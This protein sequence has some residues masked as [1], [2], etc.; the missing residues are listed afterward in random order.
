[1]TF[2]VAGFGLPACDDGLMIRRR[3]DGFIGRLMPVEVRLL[4]Q[5]RAARGLSARNTGACAVARVILADGTRAGTDGVYVSCDATAGRRTF[6]HVTFRKT[7]KTV[8]YYIEN[9]PTI[10]GVDAGRTRIDY[11]VA[12]PVLIDDTGERATL[13]GRV[14]IERRRVQWRQVLQ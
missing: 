13:N 1:M 4:H 10:E 7:R 11:L 6:V 3:V 12:H 5:A 8:R 9:G 14:E 2:G